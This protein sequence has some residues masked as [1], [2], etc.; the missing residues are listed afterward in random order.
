MSYA[1]KIVDRLGGTR[2]AAKI[3]GIPASTVQSWKVAGIIPAKW[4]QRVLEAGRALD[5]AVDPSDFF[6][7]SASPPRTDETDGAAA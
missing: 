4:H 7:L 2:A 3:L 1:S 6:D 5:P